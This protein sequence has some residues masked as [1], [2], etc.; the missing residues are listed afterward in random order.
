[1]GKKYYG[2]DIGKF[3]CALL[4]ISS[5]FASEWGHFSKSVDMLFSIYIIAVPFFFAVITPPF[6]T[7]QTFLLDVV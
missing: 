2:L 7:V 4:I 1:M 5:H 3:I 6:V